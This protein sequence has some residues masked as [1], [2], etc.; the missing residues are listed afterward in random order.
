M[1]T[2]IQKGIDLSNSSNVTSGSDERPVSANQLQSTLAIFMTAMQAENARLASNLEPKLNKLSD[3]L[4][5][6]LASVSESL[7]TKLDFV[8]DSLDAKLNSMIPNVTSEMGKENDQ[9]RQEFSPQLQTEVQL[10]TNEVEVV[11]NSTGTELTNCVQNFEG[12][13][14]KINESIIDYKSQTDASLNS[15]RLETNQNREELENKVDELTH[16]IRSVVFRLDEC[17]N[18]IQTDKQNY[19]LEIQ[20]LNSQIENLRERVNGNLANQTA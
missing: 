7:D 16:E 10:I 11:R 4:D 9:I 19:Q 2:N 8:S 1:E 15:L 17:N 20:R 14:N 5:A 12:V 13:C 6:K 18:T 3:D